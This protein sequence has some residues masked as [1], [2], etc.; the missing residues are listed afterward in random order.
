V[1]VASGTENVR[2]KGQRSRSHGYE[3]NHGLHVMWQ[4]CCCNNCRMVKCVKRAAAAA[5]AAAAAGVGLHAD[6][7]ALVSS[8]R[9]E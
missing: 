9:V 7:T 8:C 4:V 5:A 1:A 3:K 2:L 6:T